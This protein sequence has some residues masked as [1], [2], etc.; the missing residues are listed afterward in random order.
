MSNYQKF[1]VNDFKYQNTSSIEMIVLFYGEHFGSKILE[2]HAPHAPI[3]K[4]P[5]FGL[6]CI[7]RNLGAFYSEF[8][9]VEPIHPLMFGLYTQI[10]RAKSYHLLQWHWD[11][12]Y[13]CVVLGIN[14]SNLSHN[15][16]RQTQQHW[17]AVFKSLVG[18]S[19][20][21]K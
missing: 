9:V 6:M 19:V 13:L 3:S 12:K 20:T 17:Q 8:R 14:S 11:C 21:N 10:S 4:A 1:T 5:D 15:V 7:W 16:W 2:S 18:F